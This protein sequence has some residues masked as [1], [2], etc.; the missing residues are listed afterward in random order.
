MDDLIDFCKKNKKKKN[1]QKQFLE[2]D[3]RPKHQIN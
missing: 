3:T 1:K 2:I